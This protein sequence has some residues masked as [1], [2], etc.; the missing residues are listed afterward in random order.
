MIFLGISEM[1]KPIGFVCRVQ[2]MKPIVMSIK[3][4]IKDKDERNW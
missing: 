4:V 3:N 1:R 2:Y